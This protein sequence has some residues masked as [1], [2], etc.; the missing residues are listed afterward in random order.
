MNGTRRVKHTVYDVGS[1][2][3]RAEGLFKNQHDRSTCLR[4]PGVTM[5]RERPVWPT[6]NPLSDSENMAPAIANFPESL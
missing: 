1:D 3:G 6:A 4:A 5:P 2:V